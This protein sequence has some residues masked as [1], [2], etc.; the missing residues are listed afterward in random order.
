MFRKPRL[1]EAAHRIVASCTA[2]TH[3]RSYSSRLIHSSIVWGS[4]C[5]AP[6]VPGGPPR[7]AIQFASRPPFAARRVEK[8]DG[9]LY[10]VEFA[11]FKA[12]HDPIKLVDK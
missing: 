7:R 4:F 2:S 1:A 6:K 11:T 5:P 12:I 9:A 10:S 8:V 3:A